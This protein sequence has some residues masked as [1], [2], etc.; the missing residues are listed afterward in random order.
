MR[1]RQ[2]FI[3]ASPL[4]LNLAGVGARPLTIDSSLTNTQTLPL[5]ADGTHTDLVKAH[6][7]KTTPRE[8]SLVDPASPIHLPPAALS[9]NANMEPEINPNPR[10]TTTTSSSPKTQPRKSKRPK[11]N[12]QITDE[13]A[14]TWHGDGGDWTGVDDAP[15]KHPETGGWTWSTKEC[16]EHFGKNGD[17]WY[18]GGT[19]MEDAWVGGGGQWQQCSG[20][21]KGGLG[22]WHE[23]KVPP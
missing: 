1:L 23:H 20:C 21:T 2:T 15:R 17:G 22:W 4:L 11:R 12:P 14:C 6:V 5:T 9:I 16:A 7:A 10:S 8:H 13:R 19:F 3:I 18:D